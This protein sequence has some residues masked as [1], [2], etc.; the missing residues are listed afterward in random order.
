[1]AMLALTFVF[2]VHPERRVV[3]VFRR[4]PSIPLV[5]G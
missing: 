3:S 5:P 1:M 2:A 4:E